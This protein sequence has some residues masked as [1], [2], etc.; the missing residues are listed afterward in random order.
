MHRIFLY[1]DFCDDTTALRKHLW[2]K[3][4]DRTAQKTISHTY[5]IA[6]LLLEII[7]EANLDDLS[8]IRTTK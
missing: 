8:I 2:D 3:V 7:S 1:E 5:T 6:A 4:L